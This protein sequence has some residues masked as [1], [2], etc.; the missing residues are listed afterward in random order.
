MADDFR[1]RVHALFD[2]A[3]DLPPEQ[4]DQYLAQACSADPHL[5]HEVEHLNQLASDP[6]AGGDGWFAASESLWS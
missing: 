2:N 1:A 4:R 3:L 5:K 6:D